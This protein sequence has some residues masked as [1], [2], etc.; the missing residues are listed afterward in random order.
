MI[1]KAQTERDLSY[2]EIIHGAIPHRLFQPKI[3]SSAYIGSHAACNV[4]LEIRLPELPH[5]IYP[6]C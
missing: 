5:G 4:R 3:Q 2:T 6:Q 1:C